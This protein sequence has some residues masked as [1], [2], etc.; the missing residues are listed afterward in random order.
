MSSGWGIGGI[1]LN[2][3]FPYFTYG[4]QSTFDL[5]PEQPR[6][7]YEKIGSVTA[8][9]LVQIGPVVRA[10]EQFSHMQSKTNRL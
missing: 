8:I 10:L 4:N 1:Q 2:W 5:E 3:D 9:I 7:R 6:K